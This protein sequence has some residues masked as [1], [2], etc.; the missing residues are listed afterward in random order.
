MKIISLSLIAIASACIDD[1]ALGEYSEELT[2]A[3]ILGGPNRDGDT[4][5][6]LVDNCPDVPNSDAFDADGDGLGNACDADYDNS[7]SVTAADY[8]V[9]LAAF[10]TQR[11][12]PAFDP[13]ADHVPNLADAV[14]A[15][16]FSVFLRQWGAPVPSSPV[17]GIE[18][19]RAGDTHVMVV[20]TM[21]GDVPSYRIVLR[22]IV[23]VLRY[24]NGRLDRLEFTGSFGRLTTLSDGHWIAQG[25]FPC[26]D[27]GVIEPERFASNMDRFASDCGLAN[28]VHVSMYVLPMTLT[29]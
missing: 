20:T 6:D 24:P 23:S 7:G 4:L 12:A 5:P 10:G 2:V 18:A 17:V 28:A 15:A 14:N 26:F 16:D 21:N 19:A 13:R 8:G 11:G 9:F 29:P 27:T 3:E 22:R 1:A 25:G